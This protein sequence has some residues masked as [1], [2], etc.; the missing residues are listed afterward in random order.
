MSLIKLANYLCTLTAF[1][2]LLTSFIF[3]LVS[4]SFFSPTPSFQ[5]NLFSVLK[6]LQKYR[7]HQLLVYKKKG[8][9]AKA[10]LI[11]EPAVIVE[12]ADYCAYRALIMY[13]CACGKLQQNMHQRSVCRTCATC[14]CTSQK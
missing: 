6:V 3:I 2:D 4:S 1:S 14:H 9:K 5:V 13:F 8:M 7:S 11:N 12:D 10:V